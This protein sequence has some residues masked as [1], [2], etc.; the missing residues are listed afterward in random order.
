MKSLYHIA[1]HCEL[2]L[3]KVTVNNAIYLFI[4]AIVNNAIDRLKNFKIL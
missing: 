3:G 4:N 1:N 2:Q